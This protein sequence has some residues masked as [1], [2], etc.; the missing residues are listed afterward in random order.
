MEV[1]L[2]GL[3]ETDGAVDVRYGVDSAALT[4]YSAPFAVTGQ[5]VHEVRYEA[6]DAAGNVAE[7]TTTVKIDSVA[8]TAKSAFGK[9]FT[10]NVAKGAGRVYFNATDA[11][12]GVAQVRYRFNGGGWKVGPSLAVTKAGRHTIDYY[13]IDKAGNISATKSVKV[14]IIAKGKKKSAS[15]TSSSTF[16]V[17]YF[18]APQR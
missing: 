18:Y 16:D 1:A 8:P 9:Q 14:V 10:G 12:S 3:D 7:K 17:S 4:D 2:E 5:G 15:A 13:A 11:T 6:T